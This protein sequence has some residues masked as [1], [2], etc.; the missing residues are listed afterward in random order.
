M[1]GILTRLIV[2][3]ALAMFAGGAAAQA[4]EPGSGIAR[5]IEIAPGQR[6]GAATGYPAAPLEAKEVILTFDDGPNPA[7]TPRILDLLSNE[8]LRATFFPIGANAKEHP[9]LVR[10]ELSEGHTVGGHTFSHT[11]LSEIPLDQAEAEIN[12]GFAPLQAVGVPAAF[13]RLPELRASKAV[14]AWLK[15]RGIAV[16]GVDIDGSDWKGDPPDEELA[17]IAAELAKRGRG[18]II[19]HDSQ[20]N[21]AI[22][23]PRLLQLLHDQGYRIV[24]I[25]PR[26]E[27][28]KAPD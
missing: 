10:R 23:L 9:D 24:Q 26:A 28:V 3:S 18:I 21:T 19:M 12:N 8:C 6:I 2:A 17:R 27:A 1:T 22:Y 25:K 14:M 4:C 7:V 15:D 11:D 20:P 16:I 5:V 13:L